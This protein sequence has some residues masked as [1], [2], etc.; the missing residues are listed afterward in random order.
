MTIQ[1]FVNLKEIADREER[2]EWTARG[3]GSRE[4]WKSWQ[5]GLMQQILREETKRE[6][7]HE[8]NY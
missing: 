3:W 1:E 7:E 6:L 5:E 2:L 4:Q 8:W